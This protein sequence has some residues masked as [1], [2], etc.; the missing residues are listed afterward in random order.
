M[1]AWK[2]LDTAFP[3]VASVPSSKGSIGQMHAWKD[4]DTAT[5]FP[6]VASVPSSKGSI[7]V[8]LKYNNNI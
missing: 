4:L 7:I 5:A 8:S 2:D 3:L 6:L 1:H